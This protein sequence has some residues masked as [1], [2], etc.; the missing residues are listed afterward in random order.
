MPAIHSARLVRPMTD[1]HRMEQLSRAYALAVAAMAGCRSSRPEP[2]YGV[3]L[4]LR[5][6]AKRGGRRRE[7]GPT[8]YIQLKS[9][10]GATITTAEIVYDLKADAYETLRHS[11]RV[12][13][14]ILVLL[15][16]PATRA[17]WVA[18]SEDHLEIRGCAYWLSLR[19]LPARSNTTSVRVRI[20]RANQFTPAALEQIMRVVRRQEDL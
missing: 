14:A 15:A 8:L 11:T 18:H 5:Q 12:S 4:A 7:F 6:V 9:I 17:D 20:P 19:G 13:P 2:D 16:L 1:E 10:A 3:D